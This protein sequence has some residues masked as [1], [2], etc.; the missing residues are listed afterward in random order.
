MK[1]W[2]NGAQMLLVIYDRA[3]CLIAKTAMNGAQLFKVQHDFL[4]LMSGPPAGLRFV[5]SQ[6][7]KSRPGAP[8]VYGRAEFVSPEP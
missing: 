8:I 4:G 6:V 1:L 2:M 5:V 7:S 3:T